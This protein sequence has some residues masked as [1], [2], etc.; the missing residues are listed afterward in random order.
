MDD[1]KKTVTNLNVTSINGIPINESQ[2]E[3]CGGITM[4]CQ[5][6]DCQCPVYN[7][8]STSAAN[9]SSANI[10]LSKI[11]SNIIPGLKKTIDIGSSEYGINDFYIKGSIN[12]SSD[13]CG[14]LI[15]GGN[16]IPSSDISLNIGSYPDQWKD[17][18][19]CPVFKKGNKQDVTNYR[20]ISLNCSV[21][22]VFEKI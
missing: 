4:N 7:S 14:N 9:I 5:N 17:A 22:K 1:I 3:S 15:M 21:S 16:I 8:Y 12:P 19:V 11:S 20:P 2:C 18:N 13:A 10:N 6:E